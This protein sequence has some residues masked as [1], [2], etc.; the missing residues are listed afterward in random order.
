MLVTGSER[1]RCE[2]EDERPLLGELSDALAVTVLWRD[3]SVFTGKL[4]GVLAM[5]GGLTAVGQLHEPLNIRETRQDD[6]GRALPPV[7]DDFYAVK[8]PTILNNRNSTTLVVEMDAKG[9]VR[10]RRILSSGLAQYPL[11]VVRAGTGGA[12]YGSAGFNPWLE[13]LPR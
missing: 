13:S 12:V 10:S 8:N 7:D 6:A 11:G 3:D 5:P 2:I 1:I 4:V 9:A